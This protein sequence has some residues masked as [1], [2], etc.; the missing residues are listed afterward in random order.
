MVA[1]VQPLI[2]SVKEFVENKYFIVGDSLQT[3]AENLLEFMVVHDD[4]IVILRRGNTQY[5]KQ[6][7][8]YLEGVTANKIETLMNDGF[9]RSKIKNPD[10]TMIIARSF[11]HCLFDVLGSTKDK[12]MRKTYVEEIITFYFGHLATRFGD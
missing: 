5:Y 9:G 7:S 1:V 12:A 10:L 2:D 4:E 8:Q 11:L 3:V 6:F